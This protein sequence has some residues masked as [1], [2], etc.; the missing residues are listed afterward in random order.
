MTKGICPYC[1]RWVGIGAP[2]EEDCRHPQKN[3][4]L[5]EAVERTKE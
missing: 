1:K 2:H 4:T 5:R 3:M